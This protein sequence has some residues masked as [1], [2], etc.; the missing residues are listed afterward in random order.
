MSRMCREGDIS[1]CEK[2]LEEFRA[3]FD[4]EVLGVLYDT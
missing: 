2:Y 4:N 3:T 1:S